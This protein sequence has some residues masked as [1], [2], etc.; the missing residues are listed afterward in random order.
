M[1]AL[2]ELKEYTEENGESLVNASETKLGKVLKLQ[3]RPEE[4]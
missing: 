4:V 2:E 3:R 1:D